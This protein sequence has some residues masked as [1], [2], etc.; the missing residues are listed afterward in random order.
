MSSDYGHPVQPP[1]V[2]RRDEEHA[3]AHEPKPKDTRTDAQLRDDIQRRRDE[4]AKTLDALEYKLDVPARGREFV[5]QGRRQFERAWDDNPLLVGGIAAGAIVA[6]AGA[7]IGVV[8]LVRGGDAD[9]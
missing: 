3:G 7:V 9:L 1:V 5:S 2:P 6:L 8:A 4:L